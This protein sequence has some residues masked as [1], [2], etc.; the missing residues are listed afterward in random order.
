MASSSHT[1]VRW[2]K[3]FFI[4]LLLVLLLCGGF[5]GL[6]HTGP[7]LRFAARLTAAMVSGILGQE[8]RIE[9]VRGVM[10]FHLEV[11]RIQASDTGGLWLE[12]TGLHGR[13]SPGAL[14][15]GQISIT[16]AGAESI[17]LER[18][19]EWPEAEKPRDWTLPQIPGLPG[20]IRADS[21][22]VER[23][24]ISEDV[25]GIAGEFRGE[26]RYLPQ[27]RGGDWEAGLNIV[28]LDAPTTRAK[29]A[30]ALQNGQLA[31]DLLLDDTEYLPAIGAFEGPVHFALSGSGAAMDWPGTIRAMIAGRDV[32]SGDLRLAAGESTGLR[33]MATA[34]LDHPAMPPQ[35]AQYMGGTLDLD[36]VLELDPEGVLNIAMAKAAFPAGHAAIQGRID[37]KASEIDT[38]F[39][40]QYERWAEAAGIEVEEQA[41][42]SLSGAWRGPLSSAVLNLSAM[43]GEARLLESQWR[44]AL[45]ET[46]SIEGDFQVWPAPPLA[47]EEAMILLDEGLSGSIH[48]NRRPEGVVSIAALS[49]SAKG[50]KL[51]GS[52]SFD[53]A[54][55]A[56]QAHLRMDVEDPA[57][58]DDFIET[59]LPENLVL[60]A[61]LRADDRTSSFSLNLDAGSLAFEDLRIEGVLWRAQGNAA[62]FSDRFA[63]LEVTADGSVAGLAYP[64]MPPGDWTV[65]LE[66]NAA[67]LDDVQLQRFVITDKNLALHA[68]GAIS[69]ATMTGSGNL[70]LTAVDLAPIAAF[71]DQAVA[72][73]FELHS[74][75]TLP[76]DCLPLHAALDGKWAGISGLP[77]AASALLGPQG[78]LS[79][80][81][82]WSPESITARD[83]AI[84]ADHARIDGHAAYAFGDRAV[85]GELRGELPDLA[86][87]R[88]ALDQPET[89]GNIDVSLRLGGTLDDLRIAAIARAGDLRYG[90][91]SAARARIEADLEGS[92]Q[93]PQGR[94]RIELHENDRRIDAAF[95][96]AFAEERITLTDFF[97]RAGANQAAGMLTINLGGGTASGAFDL[98]APDLAY[99]SPWAGTA[100]EGTASGRIEIDTAGDPPRITAALNAQNIVTPAI[101]AGEA[102]LDAD[103]QHPLDRPRGLLRLTVNQARWDRLNLT[104]IAIEAEG[105]ADTAQATLRV[106]GLWDGLSKMDA[107]AGLTV[108]WPQ[109]ALSV[110]RLEGRLDEYPLRL[111]APARAQFSGSAFRL[112][113]ATIAIGEGDITFEAA[114]GTDTVTA[115]A[116]WRQIPL[117]LSGSFGAPP[118]SGALSGEARLS[119]APG[120]PRIDIEAHIPAFRLTESTDTPAL[121]VTA[122]GRLAEGRLAVEMNA[123]APDAA[124]ASASLKAPLFFQISPWRITLPPE[125]ALEGGLDAVAQLAPMAK[126]IDMQHHRPEG[127]FTAKFNLEG[128]WQD[129]LLTGTATL[130]NVSYENPESGTLLRNLNALLRATGDILELTRL[131][132]GDAANGRL[133]ASGHIRLGSVG[134]LPIDTTFEMKQM[135]MVR[136]DDLKAQVDGA[137]RITG[138]PDHAKIG[139]DLTLSPVYINLAPYLAASQ[140]PTIEVTE[141]NSASPREEP[142]APIAAPIIELDLQCR[143]PGR[144]F[145]SAPVFDSEWQGNLHV[146]GGLDAP[147]IAGAMQV[148]RGH[149]DFL[150][151]R[152]VLTDSIIQF[153]GQFPPEPYLNIVAVADTRDIK[154]SLRLTGALSSLSLDLSSEPP[155]PR[156]EILARVLFGKNV[157]QITPM[158]AVQLARVAAIFSS[159]VPGMQLLG[160]GVRLPGVDRIDLRTGESP[161]DTALG[162]GKYLTEQI[163]L[164]VEQGVAADSTK[165]TVRVEI[166]PQI[167]AEAQVGADAKAGGGLFWKKDY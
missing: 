138:T 50:L 58:L 36:L 156:D 95:R 12:A 87:L 42:L 20:W 135:Q 151:R 21:V 165:G 117:G 104:T 110:Q 93:A 61:D 142:K 68:T 54:A 167:S 141:I 144:L 111:E 85:S 101:R 74:Q 155:I 63:A 73:S 146:T 107:T 44:I 115:S 72:G 90:A 106:E 62:G 80:A 52:G 67:S 99:L 14:F 130:D 120:N 84:T 76:G 28:R 97:A 123:E 98:D 81:L 49:L 65:S 122:T 145:I 118:M 158:Q 26:A 13:L 64:L 38:E 43:L 154:A 163:Y 10:P 47:P 102:R 59:P 116:L 100:L 18:I 70:S 82:D 40:V 79:A 133:M 17:R 45:A 148:R 132:T 48:L 136:R 22:T 31:V 71:F 27:D 86:V 78:T 83:I 94:V 159:D 164:E 25:F 147:Q 11:E 19:P 75:V 125:G 119:G 66:A 16:E 128:V 77:E 129:P 39:R 35:A 124:T 109:G 89:A 160:G 114:Y 9:G 51:E 108:D 32:F 139:G 88:E 4:A 3:R 121:E 150:G 56:L 152:F 149:L 1:A 134:R 103:I 2:L 55:P 113:P 23:F 53:P 34:D 126:W 41:P 5:Y 46:A 162:L 15:G 60:T 140:L 37:L 166:T 91:F 7:G 112:T 161:E 69:P 24:T 127:V 157:A 29:I 137:I 8:V 105:G 6:L 57:A 131:E 153:G 92:V 30:I 96:A 33:L 143:I